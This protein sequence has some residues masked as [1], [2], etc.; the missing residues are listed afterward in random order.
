MAANEGTYPVDPATLVGQVRLWIGDTDATNVADGKG[1]F[2]WVS[3]QEIEGYLGLKAN[4]PGRAAIQILRL[5]AMTPALQYKK[6]SSADL[7]VDGATITRALRDLIADIE[8]SLDSED[9]VA[10]SDFAKLVDTGPAVAQRALL[11]RNPILVNGIAL[12][13]TLPIV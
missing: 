12:D 7:S 10:G 3:D 6:W 11:P 2:M 1:T 4:S 5:V 9:G 13:P 8:K